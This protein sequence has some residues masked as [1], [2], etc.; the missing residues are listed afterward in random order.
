MKYLKARHHS[1][2]A[3]TDHGELILTHF[4]K[5]IQLQPQPL[6]SL[7]DINSKLEEKTSHGMHMDSI[8]ALE[9]TI[10]LLS[11]LDD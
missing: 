1:G 9:V 10:E 4:M 11:S 6:E 2:G 5:R 8:S 7:G 3:A